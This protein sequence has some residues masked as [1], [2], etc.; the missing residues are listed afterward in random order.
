MEERRNRRA[1]AALGCAVAALGVSLG[2]A[3]PLE[4]ACPRPASAAVGVETGFTTE[5]SCR[6]VG[7]VRGPARL[8]FGGRLDMNTAPA[9]ALDALP[10]IGP[11]RADALVRARA[12]RPFEGVEDLVRADGIGPATAEG[13]AGWV[14]FARESHMATQGGR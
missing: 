2:E 5:V 10:G 6:G 12:E 9:A 1:V 4:A 13:L 3:G 7:E 11:R 8:L 14:E